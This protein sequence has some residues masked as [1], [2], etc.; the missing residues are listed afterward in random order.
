[1]AARRLLMLAAAL[2]LLAAL[3]SAL[4]PRDD[5][6]DPPTAGTSLPA[7][8]TVAEEIPAA[9]GSD[10]QVEVRRGD[11]LEL[12]VA[13]DVLDTVLIEQLD[14]LDAIEPTTP[15]RFN[16]VIDAPA[17]TYPIRLVDADRRVGSLIVS[18]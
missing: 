18:D 2:L 9:K 10:S 6:A 7:G 17:G 14:F 13:G 11:L 8:R 4:V 16:L 1:M 5:G 3:A 15:A 12:E